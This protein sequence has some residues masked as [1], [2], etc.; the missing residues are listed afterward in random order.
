MIDDATAIAR[1]PSTAEFTKVKSSSPS[2][3]LSELGNLLGDAVGSVGS[4]VGS[5]VD[6]TARV[7]S[8]ALAAISESVQ[9]L[10]AASSKRR[11]SKDE[12]EHV[13]AEAKENATPLSHRW[14]H[15]ASHLVLEQLASG[16]ASRTDWQEEETSASGRAEPVASRSSA[17]DEMRQYWSVLA[18][19][20]KEDEATSA[21]EDELSMV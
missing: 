15:Q 19:L 7:G 11:R 3:V 13:R 6:S 12:E 16:K 17:T 14:E 20:A 10:I 5:T 18:G 8:S 2:N 4:T 1:S 9:D 21:V